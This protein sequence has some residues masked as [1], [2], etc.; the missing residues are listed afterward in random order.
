MDLAQTGQLHQPVR[1]LVACQHDTIR[2]ASAPS[3][4][5]PGVPQ[6]SSSSDPGIE[7]TDGGGQHAQGDMRGNAQAPCDEGGNGGLVEGLG[8]IE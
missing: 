4:S 3:P 8:D 1:G 6:G 7:Q 5:V 2:N